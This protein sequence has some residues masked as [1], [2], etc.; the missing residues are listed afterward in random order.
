MK[1]PFDGNQLYPIMH[2]VLMPMY[3]SIWQYSRTILAAINP[4]NINSIIIYLLDI[5]MLINA[6]TN[7]HK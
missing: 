3:A 6:Y 1:R 7:R 5:N 4:K 2:P